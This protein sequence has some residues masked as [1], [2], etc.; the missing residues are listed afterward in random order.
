VA[1]VYGIHPIEL[2]PGVSVA[3]FEQFIHGEGAPLFQ[4]PNGAKVS[5]LKGDRGARAGR[6]AVLLEFD[7]VE[8]RNQTFPTADQSTVEPNPQAALYEKFFS[9]VS[10]VG[11][12]STYTDYVVV[13]E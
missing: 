6:Y 12:P 8:A 4:T 5:I 11:D 2:K 13:A 1:K 3:E 10:G 9:L 7:S